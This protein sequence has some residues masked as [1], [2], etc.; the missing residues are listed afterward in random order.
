MSRVLLLD[1]TDNPEVVG[2]LG[3]QLAKLAKKGVHIVEG[4]VVPINQKLE[5]GMS[6]EVLTAF[7]RRSSAARR[8]ARWLT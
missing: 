7:D 3:S 4:F 2:Q 6:N 1:D 8:T 5:F